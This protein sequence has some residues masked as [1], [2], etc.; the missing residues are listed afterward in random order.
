MAIRV[1]YAEDSALLREGVSRML[2]AAPGIELLGTCAN[3]DDVLRLAAA[4]KPDIVVT[5]IRMPPTST[6]EGIR[7]ASALQK[8]QPNIGVIVLSQHADPVY[9]QTLLENGSA[10]RGYLLKDRVADPES[11]IESIRT[12]AA[13]G[14]VVDPT[15][16]EALVAIRSRQKA[17]PLNFLTTR[18]IEILREM[19][20]GRNN[21]AIAARL[22]L[23]ERAVEK[24]SNTIFAKLL[25]TEE[26]DVNRRVKAVLVYLTETV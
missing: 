17:S 19:A 15:V 25:L 12:V 16:I 2:A 22:E 3:Y 10:R 8:S 13:G 26:P 1:I 5:D 24:H 18:E 23:T 14:S 6:D 11:L 20:Q 7:I 21:A 4:E 9:A